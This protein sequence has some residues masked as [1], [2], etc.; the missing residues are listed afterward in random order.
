MVCIERKKKSIKRKQMKGGNDKHKTLK[1]SPERKNLQKDIALSQYNKDQE[2]R[3]REQQ[4]FLKDAKKKLPHLEHLQLQGCMKR[5]VNSDAPRAEK[6]ISN[7]M[8]LLEQ[9]YDR[10]YGYGPYGNRTNPCG[11]KYE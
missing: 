8:K 10:V 7:D 2:Q 9:W 5:L 6:L 4:R 1:R 11:K 3:K